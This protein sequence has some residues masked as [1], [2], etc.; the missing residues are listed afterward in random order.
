MKGKTGTIFGPI[1]YNK[2]K[3]ECLVANVDHIKF[4]I[5]V[6]LEEQFG[7]LPLP[8]AG[9]DSNLLL[10]TLKS[11]TQLF[12]FRIYCCCLS[13]LCCNWVSEGSPLSISPCKRRPNYCL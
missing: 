6:A 2:N 12:H 11:N 1:Q 5:E 9:M 10:V 13:I 4:D 8:F 7:A 3:M